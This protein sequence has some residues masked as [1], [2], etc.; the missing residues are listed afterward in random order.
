[1]INGDV[2]F[3]L[4]SL[5]IGIWYYVESL[6]FP[7]GI[8]GVPGPAFYPQLV[9]Y[10]W[11]LLS[12]LLFISGVKNKKRYF[13]YKLSDPRIKRGIIVIIVTFL[14]LILWGKGRFVIN[15]TIYLGT[16]MLILGEK[17]LNTIIA[18]LAISFFVYYVFNNLFNV[19]LF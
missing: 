7:P 9:F 15:T 2:V 10:I 16:I 14:Y 1:M 11:V 12:I 17:L 3:S 4:V 8:G 18:A 6:K 13:S 19:L 5:A